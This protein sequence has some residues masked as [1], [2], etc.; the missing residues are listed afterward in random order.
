[1][2]KKR[3]GLPRNSATYAFNQVVDD[4]LHGVRVEATSNFQDWFGGRRS[5]EISEDVVG[6][7]RYGK[8]LTVLYDINV[9]EPE[10]EEDEEA[11][12][13]SWTPRFKH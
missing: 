4:V 8:T 7:G 9:P 1:M 5:I 12:I 10:D 13:E 2:A 6:L 11:L 3:E